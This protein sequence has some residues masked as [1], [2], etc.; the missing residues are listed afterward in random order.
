MVMVLPDSPSHCNGP[1]GRAIIAKVDVA[2]G[3]ID[4]RGPERRTFD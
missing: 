1:G 3:G 4:G 2:T